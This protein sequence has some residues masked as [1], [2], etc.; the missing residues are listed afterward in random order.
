MT[1]RCLNDQCK[2]CHLLLLSFV[3]PLFRKFVLIVL[4]IVLDNFL[5]NQQMVTNF[6]VSEV[7][8][9]SWVNIVYI[10]VTGKL[11]LAKFVGKSPGLLMFHIQIPSECCRMTPKCPVL[12]VTSLKDRSSDIGLMGMS[13]DF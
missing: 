11:I 1:M 8:F 5:F 2:G 9:R 6:F 12:R 10:G 4:S 3:L 13:N 7:Y